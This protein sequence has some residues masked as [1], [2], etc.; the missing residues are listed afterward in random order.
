MLAHLVFSERNGWIAPTCRA[1][2]PWFAGPVPDPYPCDADGYGKGSMPSSWRIWAYLFGSAR[3][4]SVIIV[5]SA[6]RLVSVKNSRAHY[7]VVSIRILPR[8][9]CLLAGSGTFG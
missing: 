4:R 2:G 3:R 8:S 1:V 6:A 7:W 9:I 5:R